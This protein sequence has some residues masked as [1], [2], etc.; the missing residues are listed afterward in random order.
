M[1]RE[2]DFGDLL[3]SLGLLPPK[4]EFELLPKPDPNW[5]LSPFY[6]GF[7]LKRLL[8]NGYGFPNMSG[9]DWPN[10]E[11]GGLSDGFPK[12]EPLLF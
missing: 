8:D 4:S 2:N 10:I 3:S 7:E 5:G 12:R 1:A 11:P 9:F 6:W